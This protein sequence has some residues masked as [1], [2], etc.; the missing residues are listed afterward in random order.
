MAVIAAVNLKGGVGKTS[1]CLHL[2]GALAQLG[3]RILLVDN[4]PQSSLT[5]GF[6]GPQPARQLDPSA[7]VS[8]IHVGDEPFPE[9]VIRSSGFDR[10]D[11]LPGSRFAASFNVPDP[12]RAPYEDQVRLR[13][14]LAQVREGYD[15]VIIDC[16]PNLHMA[17]WAAMAASD[18]LLVPVMPEDFGAQGTQDVAES[19]AM[20][21]AVVNPGLRMLGYL[22]S[23][24]QARRTVHQMYVERLRAGQ[25]EAVFEAMIPAAVDYVEAITALKP[26]TCHKP[27]SAAAKAVKAVADEVLVRIAAHAAAGERGA[28]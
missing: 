22:V 21:R 24:Y 18:Y 19:A 4:D 15:L 26:V 10:I 8:A 13:D 12:H 14:F 2:A 3:R 7:T 17:S 5:A 28:A 27:K 9:A 1:T 6:L 16:P 20:V 23:M 11:L 25:G